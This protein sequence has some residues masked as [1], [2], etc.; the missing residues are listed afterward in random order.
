MFKVEPV[1][2][3]FVVNVEFVP[4]IYPL[5]VFI[6]VSRVDPVLARLVTNVLPVKPRFV[7]VA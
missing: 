1:E 7:M 5:K 2:A 3:R 4:V 6:L